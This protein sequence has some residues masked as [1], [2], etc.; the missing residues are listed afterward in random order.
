MRGRTIL[1]VD[2]AGP[3]CWGSSA[4][5]FAPGNTLDVAGGLRDAIA[6][7]A[8]AYDLVITDVRLG[9]GRVSPCMKIGPLW[10]T[11]PA[12]PFLFATGDKQ[13]RG[14]GRY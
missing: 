11:Q 5:R 3:T 2:R 13:R 6:R 7:A 12:P 9:R 14:G 8:R 10:A 1:L 4:R